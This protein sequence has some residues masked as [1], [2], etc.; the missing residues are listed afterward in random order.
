[1]D[2]TAD[3]NEPSDKHLGDAWPSSD[4]IH[5][6]AKPS[7]S[8]PADPKLHKW[9]PWPTACCDWASLPQQLVSITSLVVV[10]YFNLLNQQ[11]N[12]K[13]PL[14]PPGFHPS[15]QS[16]R[17][18]LGRKNAVGGQACNSLLLPSFQY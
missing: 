18:S 1:M 3:V 17:Y 16:L 10:R 11:R 14:F 8:D 12:K 13:L 15:L 4:E 6:L 9:R 2:F 7:H 5:S